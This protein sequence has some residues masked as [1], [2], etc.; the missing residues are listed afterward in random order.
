LPF[1]IQYIALFFIKKDWSHVLHAV[2]V[3]LHAVPLVTRN[4]R[5]LSVTS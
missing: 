1:Q 4:I 3:L 2:R 5:N